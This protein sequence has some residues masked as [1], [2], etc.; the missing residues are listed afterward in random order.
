MASAPAKPQ[1][2]GSGVS[3]STYGAIRASKSDL[4]MLKLPKALATA[5]EDA[6]EG[7]VLGTLTFTKGGGSSGGPQAKRQ[8][9]GAG[10][11]TSSKITISVDPTLAEAQS[12]LPVDYTLE[13]MTKKTAGTLHP[14][15]RNADGSVAIHG[16]VSRTATAQVASGD[17]KATGGDMDANTARY[18]TL[19]KNRLL[20]T[21]VNSKRFVQPGGVDAAPAGPSKAATAAASLGKGFGGSVARFGKNMLDAQERSKTMMLGDQSTGPPIVGMEAVRSTLFE[22]FSK[23]QFWAVKELRLA[24]GGRL[25]EKETRDVLRDIADYHRIGEHKN[26]WELKAEYKSSV[27]TSTEGA[28]AD[29]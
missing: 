20:E 22:Y 23:R 2:G 7:T 24:S 6:P 8:K 5:W 18:R 26:M 9:T 14:F 15:T 12:D 17:S 16:V 29:K 19:L 28:A 4:W 21:T 1:P 11:A 27:T 10:P 3:G 13:A 25:P